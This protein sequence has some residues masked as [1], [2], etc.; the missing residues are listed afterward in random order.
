MN[1]DGSPDRATE[2]TRETASRASAEEESRVRNAYA[3]RNDAVE[4]GRYSPFERANL[5]RLQ[6]LERGCL[7]LLERHG[8]RPLENKK[9]LEIGC[10]SGYWLRE[11]IQWGARPEHLAGIDLLPDRIAEAT[12]LCPAGVTLRCGSATS[13]DLPDAAFDV[14]AQFVVFTSVLDASVKR[15]I[16]REML[17]VL[18]PDGLILWYDFHVDNPRNPDVRGVKKSEIR[19]LFP[20]CTIDLR[21]ITLAPPLGRKVV[22]FSR[23]LYR[24]LSGIPFLCTHYVGAICKSPAPSGASCQG[25]DH[26]RPC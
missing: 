9:I 8:C 12:R 3:R 1:D 13:L 23:I 24:F 25:G 16:A 22:R 17:R 7:M 18:K 15:A 19:R 6:E 10:G 21:R 26:D 2:Q 14:A 20:G 5:L 11:F 4:P